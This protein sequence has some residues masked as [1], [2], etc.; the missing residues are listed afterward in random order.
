[1]SYII[2]KKGDIKKVSGEILEK[3]KEK[4]IHIYESTAEA[5]KA[6]SLAFGGSTSDTLYTMVK[7]EIKVL[8]ESLRSAFEDKGFPVY[9][10]IEALK[11]AT[12]K[13]SGTPEPGM[14]E[15]VL[16]AL[17]RR[18]SGDLSNDIV[19]IKNGG[20]ADLTRDQQE[21]M[22]LAM[23]IYD[24]RSD[25]EVQH[26]LDKGREDR[27]RYVGQLDKDWDRK[28][29]Y[30]GEGEASSDGPS[31]GEILMPNLSY[32]QSKGAGGVSKF[33]GGMEDVLGGI[34]R[35]VRAVLEE[36]TSSGDDLT[37]TQRLAE[38]IELTSPAGTFFELGVSAMAPGALIEK[39]G[40]RFINRSLSKPATTIRK[41]MGTEE[42]LRDALTRTRGVPQY[43]KQPLLPTPG[44]FDRASLEAARAGVAL[45]ETAKG[46]LKGAGQG[47]AYSAF[48]AAVR[49]TSPDL[50]TSEG[51]SVGLMDLGLGAAGGGGVGGV[52]GFGKGA[53][54]SAK[55][56]DDIA[57]ALGLERK[58]GNA[59]IKRIGDALAREE[60]RKTPHPVTGKPTPGKWNP[61]SIAYRGEASEGVDAINAYRQGLIND[62][63]H[64]GA[65]R[66]SGLADLEGS[67]IRTPKATQDE[68]RLI[69]YLKKELEYTAPEDAAA[70]RQALLP[71]PTEKPMTQSEIDELKEIFERMGLTWDDSYALSSSASEAVPEAAPVE[72]FAVSPFRSKVDE[73][74]EASGATSE[75]I[76]P[77]DFE[78]VGTSLR[79]L[80]SKRTRIGKQMEKARGESKPALKRVYAAYS[81]AID[82]EL[83]RLEGLDIGEAK[84][85]IEKIRMSNDLFRKNYQGE[86]LLPA[87]GKEG[88][89]L[90]KVG[91]SRLRTLVDPTWQQAKDTH[92]QLLDLGLPEENWIL[93]SAVRAYRERVKGSAGEPISSMWERASNLPSSIGIV[94]EGAKTAA[95]GTA[96]STVKS[97]AAQAFPYA[98]DKVEDT[99]EVTP[100][101]VII[102]K[103]GLVTKPLGGLVKYKSVA[104]IPK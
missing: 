74:S 24:S 72:T 96:K 34:P 8:P 81:Q 37:F 13:A 88:E 50:S 54:S 61:S 15:H 3:A 40:A 58:G 102:G 16:N 33:I 46:M 101:L 95:V 42:S 25:E 31:V 65:I 35:G 64:I 87:P 11:Q 93:P 52:L 71:S 39:G 103:G 14:R 90:R 78:P 82:D 48:P 28:N 80:I 79:D 36:S 44:A 83:S 55:S 30:V 59:S 38:P 29:W 85:G 6:K 43:T 17:D 1:M 49:G 70:V 22:M 60:M 41:A 92:N 18:Y 77:N 56:S 7:G 23:D 10:S 66:E 47:L 100:Q 9:E 75:G 76:L 20:K 4:G 91:Q 98:V 69:P 27:N 51:L 26:V 68:S 12:S 62:R 57:S 73:F 86:E 45:P 104:D 53:L 32:R 5:E 99:P 97:A 19:R 84:A 2:N 94:A 89:Y 21:L 67:S 63:A